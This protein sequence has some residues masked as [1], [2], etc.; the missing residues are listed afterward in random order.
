L[1]IYV[2]GVEALR[3]KERQDETQFTT[4]IDGFLTFIAPL[5]ANVLF[6]AGVF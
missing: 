6:F 4:K 2:A 5:N 1:K 3:K